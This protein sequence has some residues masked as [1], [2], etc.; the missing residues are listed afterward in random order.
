V[1]VKGEERCEDGRGGRG[2]VHGGRE[3]GGGGERVRKRE[4][5]EAREGG[6]GRGIVVGGREMDGRE[7]GKGKRG[8]E[9]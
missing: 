4:R 8:G 7:G 3:V 5:G 1:E 6:G 2:R 9:G